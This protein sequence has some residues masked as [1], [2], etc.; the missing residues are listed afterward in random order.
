MSASVVP[1]PILEEEPVANV[2]CGRTAQARLRLLA[3]RLAVYVDVEGLPDADFAGKQGCG[4][5]NDPSIVAEVQ[6][7]KEPVI[8]HLPLELLQR[9]RARS[10]E[11]S[12]P[13]CEGLA[14]GGGAPI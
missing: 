3:G 12:E 1:A 11:T 7:F 2:P 13:V 10:S 8:S 9:P 5:F 14:E 4:A 6:A